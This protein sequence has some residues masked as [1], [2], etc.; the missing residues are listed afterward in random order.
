M[1][2]CADGE[3]ELGRLGDANRT[4]V[5]IGAGARPR[6]ERRAVG[7]GPRLLRARRLL[8]PRASAARP[9]T[10]CAAAP[11]RAA[12]RSPS[13]T[14]RTPTSPRSAPSTAR[15]GSCV[16]VDE[17]RDTAEQGPDPRG[18]PQHHLLRP[19]RLRHPGRVAG[20]LR[21]GRRRAHRRPRAPRWPRSSARPAATPPRTSWSGSQGRWSY[22]L[23]G[24]VEKGWIAQ[25]ERDAQQF[26]KIAK[27]RP[28]VNARRAQR[29]PGRDGAPR[30][31]AARLSTRTSSAAA[32][33]GVTTT[34]DAEPA[35]RG[36]QGGRRAS[37]RPRRPRA[38]A[39]VWS[40][41]SPAPATSSRCTAATT[42]STASSTTRPR[43]AP[44]PARPSSRSRSPPALENGIELNSRWDGRSPRTFEWRA[45]SL[46]GQQ[47]RRRVVRHTSPC[48]RRRRTRSTPSTSTSASRSAATR[49]ST[50]RAAPASPTGSSI[51]PGP[52]VVLGTASVDRL[53]DG[54]GLRDVRRRAASRSPTPRSWRSSPPAGGTLYKAEPKGDE[55]FTPEVAAGVTKALRGVVTN[56]SGFEAKQLGRPSAGKTGTTNENKSAWYVGYTAAAGGGGGPVQDQRRPASCSRSRAWRGCPR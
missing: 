7:R 48:S 19:R 41:S 55:A 45:A 36:R 9:G 5:A 20:V 15:R 56:G 16:L 47:L 31:R 4:S 33:C 54:R 27:R 21:Q 12:R 22:V 49:S 1:L 29:L 2:Y 50:P 42:T 44:R 52:A 6:A 51:D 35:G 28:A 38:C 18:L 10:T 39:S 26:P 43:S 13:S 53:P 25:A 46:Q 37:A 11:P 24:M 14:P 8:D 40:P 30:A 3:T 32:G 23:D 17:A 34:F